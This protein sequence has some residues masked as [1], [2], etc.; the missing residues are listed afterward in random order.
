MQLN[1]FQELPEQCD[2]RDEN[3]SRKCR[4]C[5]VTKHITKFELSA[6]K[7][8]DRPTYKYTCHKCAY[9]LKK[10]RNELR[11]KHGPPAD[12]CACCGEY[13]QTKLDHCHK[14]KKFRGWLCDFCNR[15]IGLLGDNK[16]GVKMAIK[17]LEGTD[18]HS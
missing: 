9:Q 1:L 8:G 4:V 7:K 18:G 12:S 5:N 16:E 14:T 2:K 11:K 6:Y 13:T 10:E 17:Y 3:N 15:G